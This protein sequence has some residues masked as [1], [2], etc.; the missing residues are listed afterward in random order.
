MVAQK[1]VCDG[2]ARES[3]QGRAKQGARP[4]REVFIQQPVAMKEECADGGAE[5]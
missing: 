5:G 2:Q 3:R 4:R 1:G